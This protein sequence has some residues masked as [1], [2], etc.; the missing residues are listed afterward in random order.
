MLYSHYDPV[1]GLKRELTVHLNEVY[2][3]MM[4][5]VN[6]LS[7]I[8]LFKGIDNVKVIVKLIAYLHDIGKATSFFQKMLFNE[9]LKQNELC[10]TKHSLLGAVL[11]FCL[12]EQLGFNS[13]TSN[14]VYRIIHSHHSSFHKNKDLLQLDSNKLSILR[15][16]YDDIIKHDESNK[17]IDFISKN[18]NCPLP[19][20]KDFN[21]I[22]KETGYI[23]NKI[24]DFTT[25]DFGLNNNETD[26]YSW[27]YFFLLSALNRADKYNASFNSAYDMENSN[28]TIFSKNLSPSLIERHLANKKSSSKIPS[29]PLISSLRDDFFLKVKNNANSLDLNHHLYSIYA[30][31]GIGKTLSLLNAAIIIQNKLK[32][33]KNQNYKII[34]GLPFLSI[35]DQ[36]SEEITDILQ[37]ANYEINWNIFQEYHHLS[38]PKVSSEEQEEEQ[39]KQDHIQLLSSFW[40]SQII[41]TTFVSLLETISDS[42]QSIKLASLARS[43]IIIDEVQ[44]I[45]AGLY[46]YVK[47]FIMHLTTYLDSYVIISSATMPDCFTGNEFISL[48]GD[49]DN[50]EKPFRELNRYK[51]HKPVEYNFAQFTNYVMDFME[52]QPDKYYLIVA[53]TRRM[54]YEL[55]KWFTEKKINICFLSTLIIPFQRKARIK[56]IREGVKPHLIISTQLIEAG[57]DMSVDYIFRFLAPLDNIIQTAGRT[58]RHFESGCCFGSVDL[59]DMC[60]D[61]NYKDYNLVYVNNSKRTQGDAKINATIKLLDEKDTYYEKEMVDL[62]KWYFKELSTANYWINAYSKLKEH[63]WNDFGNEIRIIKKELETISIVVDYK[64]WS[65]KVSPIW[66]KYNDLLSQITENQGNIYI[67]KAELKDNL[68]Q[69]SNFMLNINLN[70]TANLIEFDK[71]KT[72]I[73]L[74][75]ENY[76]PL[77]GLDIFSKDTIT[78][79]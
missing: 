69:L 79:F 37:L 46:E 21:E 60:Y 73:Q 11:G 68:R 33:D 14:I 10:Y 39:Y 29:S 6:S 78:C 47:W 32:E 54:A 34:Y 3:G 61:K 19:N 45:D 77:L 55:A 63:Q 72:G 53:N 26:F 58:N 64:D 59:I 7:E 22:T 1:K 30:P 12:T 23:V 13:I 20:L 4:S 48:I 75:R 43:I 56:D 67:L 31:T 18:I 44:S 76:D 65:G 27:L 5:I 50:V 9:P 24:I 41:L 66:E 52:K 25:D 36:V 35:I 62:S 28:H 70:D 51:I 40:D 42:K 17:I 49:K 2:T 16:Q 74:I 57:V 38:T 71:S 8:E 15:T